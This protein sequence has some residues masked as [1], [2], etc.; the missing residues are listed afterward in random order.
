MHRTWS[1]EDLEREEPLLD[2]VR[3]NWACAYREYVTD[4]ARLVLANLRSAVGDGAS[5]LS[6]APV[7]AILREDGRAAGLEAACALSGGR[8]RVRA[9]RGGERRRTLGG[10][11]RAARGSERAAAPPPLEGRPRGAARRAAAGAPPRDPPDR[12]SPLDLRGAARRRRLPRHHR[13]ELRG[14]RRRVAGGDA[15]GRRV[16]ARAGE[17]RL[18]AWS[19]CAPSDV[20]AAWCGPAA[21]RRRA[22]QAGARDVAQGR[23]VDRPGG[24]RDPRRRQADRLPADGARHARA[25]RRVARVSRIADAGEE[26]PLVGGDFGGDARRARGGAPPRRCRSSPTAT[27]ARLA[28]L[29]GSEARDV[30]RARPRAPRRRRAAG[31]RRDRVGGDARGRLPPRGRPLPAHARGALRSRRRARP[32]SAPA[33]ARMAELLGWS[34]TRRAD[35]IARARA[36]LAADLVFGEEQR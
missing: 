30:L 10:R 20:V 23:G 2:R 32:R 27:A 31:D 21:A 24:R 19:R 14:R 12:G 33:A 11:G 6:H 8:C 26:P 36:R 1:R 13:H 9:Q 3:Y 5:V 25:R 17:P 34:D 4:D 22:G 28:R 35:E 29:Y 7:C 16:P 15:R 18:P